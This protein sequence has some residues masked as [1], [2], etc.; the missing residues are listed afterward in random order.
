MRHF[1]A[2]L[3]IETLNSKAN[4]YNLPSGMNIAILPARNEKL[5]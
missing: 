2:G 1:F 5:F 4:S 3:T